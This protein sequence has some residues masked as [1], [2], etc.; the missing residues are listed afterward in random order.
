M[1]VCAGGGPLYN[2]IMFGSCCG[3]VLLQKR[4]FLLCVG[5]WNCTYSWEELGVGVLPVFLLGL[6]IDEGLCMVVVVVVMQ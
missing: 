6:T 5:H 1:M 2:I 3:L 4:V